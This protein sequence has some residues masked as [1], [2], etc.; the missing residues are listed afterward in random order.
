MASVTA[1]FMRG[2]KRY[3]L[4]SLADYQWVLQSAYTQYDILLDIG[5]ETDQSEIRKSQQIVGLW[6]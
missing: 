4:V 3:M 1:L 6:H 2:F 5:G